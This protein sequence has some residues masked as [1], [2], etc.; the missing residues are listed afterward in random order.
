MRF[1]KPARWALGVVLVIAAL[2][3]GCELGE[4]ILEAALK[5]KPSK[6]EVALTTRRS[7]DQ[8]RVISQIGRSSRAYEGD[9]RQKAMSYLH[10]SY[11]SFGLKPSLD[12]VQIIDARRNDFSTNVELQQFFKG[13]PVENA[14]LQINFD[15]DGHVVHVVSSYTPPVNVSELITVSREQAIVIARQEFLRTTPIYESKVDEQEQKGA[16][17]IDPKD[18]Q[19]AQEPKVDD[20]YFV[21]KEQ[22][23]RAYRTYISAVKPFGAKEIITDASGGDVL[24]IRNFVYNAV[25]GHGQVFIPNPVNALNNDSLRDIF[26][27]NGAVPSPSA[28]PTAYVP[29]ILPELDAPP[30]GPF[31]LKG[32][33]V[34]LTN[35]QDPSNTPPT[36][37][38]VPDFM[39]ERKSPNFEEVMVYYHV[40]RMERYIQTLGFTNVMK[41]QIRA[42]AHACDGADNSSYV[43]SPT[44]RGNGDLLFGD[45]GVDDAEDADVIAHEYGHAIQDNQTLGKY[46]VDA[47]ETRAMAEGFS[48]YWALSVYKAE[49]EKSGYDLPCLMEWDDIR[50]DHHCL[51][52]IELSKNKD[53]LSANAYEN[54]AIWSST[55]YEIFRT[56]GKEPADGLILQSHFNVPTGPTFEQAAD[57]ILVAALQRSMADKIPGL[58]VVF[59]NH[60]IY[61]PNHCPTVS[62]PIS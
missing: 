18:V 36:V 24:Q 4:E 32:P 54:G 62:L 8:T 48:D 21:R 57:A 55:L 50:P 45:G 22:L 44:T 23:H 17:V 61:Q 49:T 10:D 42:D 51:R 37:T 1:P 33:Y 16:I 47:V 31:S 27:T 14:R 28:S 58:C 59:Q 6:P 13:L 30:T 9:P 46:E 60:K 5:P 20:V 11:G 29:V 53:Q 38:S 7:P 39:Y 43:S 2:K 26:N 52:H 35:L 3:G 25:D 40:D 41:R 15:K 12:D 34:V 19:L 56:L